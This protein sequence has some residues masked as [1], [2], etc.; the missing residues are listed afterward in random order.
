[1]KFNELAF[2][3]AMKE[4]FGGQKYFCEALGV[5][6]NTPINFRKRGGMSSGN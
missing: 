6:A 1:M 3:K 4:K 2:I 5:S